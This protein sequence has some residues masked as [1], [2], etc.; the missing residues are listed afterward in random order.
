MNKAL[1]QISKPPFVRRINKAKLP[2]QFSQLTFTVYNRRTDP[3]E[4]VSHFTQ[5]MAVHSSNKALMCK[6]FPSSLWPIAMRW[7]DALEEESIMSFEEL[8]RAFGTKFITCSRVS[9]LVDS[10]LS[11]TMREGETLKTYSDKYWETWPNKKGGDPSRRNQSLYCNYHQDKGY[12][13]KDCSTLRDHLN[14]LVKAGKLG[15]FLYQ[16]TS[17]YGHS[18]VRFQKDGAPRPTLGTINVIFAR[19]R[20]D[21]GACSGVMSVVKGSNLEDRNRAPKK[22]KMM[23]TPT[24]G[25]LEEDKMGTLQLH[26][27]ALVVT[28]RINGYDVK[29][30]SVDQGSKT[31]I[32]YLDLYKGLNLK[33]EHLESYDSLRF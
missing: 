10:L 4:H 32:M 27:D 17:Q 30:V 28:I 15:Q 2:Q 33:P 3:V 19:P 7:F 16:P 26:D 24:L 23:T 12:T 1:Q 21:V 11:M 5:K 31:E 13:T 29:R 22:A 18:R 6:V 25:F 8:T 9:K 14:Q 20:G